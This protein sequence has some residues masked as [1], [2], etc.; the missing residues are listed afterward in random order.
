MAL[1]TLIHKE[2]K[3]YIKFN[4]IDIDDDLGTYY[5]FSDN[6]FLPIWVSTNLDDI[7]YLMN[8]KLVSVPPIY[9]M[10]CNR[11]SNEYINLG[12]YEILKLV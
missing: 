10:S 9:A 4:K 8:P 7:E 6:K 11:P 2:T 1:W 3:E 12:D 5:Y